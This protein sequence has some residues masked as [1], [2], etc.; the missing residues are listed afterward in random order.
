MFVIQQPSSADKP[1]REAAS[2]AENG[3]QTINPT[4]SV[5]GYNVPL[6]II[7]ERMYSVFIRSAK[8]ERRG[9]RH[10]PWC[11]GSGPGG[12]GTP[13]GGG[14]LPAAVFWRVIHHSE[15]SSFKSALH[16]REAPG[17][18]RIRTGDTDSSKKKDTALVVG[19]RPG[20]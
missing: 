8:A 12:S 9:W 5:L 2:P 11:H 6:P 10:P 4:A 3:P 19:L 18:E 13:G 14:G 1:V 20:A 17:P 7:K 16:L 15:C